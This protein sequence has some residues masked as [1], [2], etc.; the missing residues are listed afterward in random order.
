MYVCMYRYTDYTHYQTLIIFN[1]AGDALWDQTLWSD[2]WE[3]PG[4]LKKR[5]KNTGTP[6]EKPWKTIASQEII[7][8]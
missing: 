7:Y 5:W 6:L 8:K 3:H 2:F 4:F 1:D